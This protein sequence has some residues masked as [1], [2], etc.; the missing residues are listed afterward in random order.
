MSQIRLE[1]AKDFGTF[2]GE[3]E[4]KHSYISV[5]VCNNLE[6]IVS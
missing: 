3:G 1:L 2:N 4:T 5:D 6:M